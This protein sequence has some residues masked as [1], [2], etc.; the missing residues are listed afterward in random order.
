M[1]AAGVGVC[2]GASPV[3]VGHSRKGTAG[4]AVIRRRMGVCAGAH[5]AAAVGRALSRPAAMALVR[6][7]DSM[8]RGCAGCGGLPRA[9]GG[10]S[11]IAAGADSR[12][13]LCHIA[14]AA[15]RRADR[16]ADRASQAERASGATRTSPRPSAA[17][18]PPGGDGSR[19]GRGFD[20]D[21]LRWMWRAANS[22]GGCLT[23]AQAQIA[24]DG[25]PT[26]E[27]TARAL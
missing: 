18:S 14:A 10:R 16:R 27:R 23:S 11:Y 15:L 19:S 21:G 6:V 2:G 25:R 7:E 12:G 13:R 22:R 9:G 5:L 26:R 17:P 24:G 1:V 8:P 3:S 20:A 4:A